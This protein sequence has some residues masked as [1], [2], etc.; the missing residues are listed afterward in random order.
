MR[1][2]HSLISYEEAREIINKNITQ[3]ERTEEVGLSEA[4]GRVLYEDIKS[5]VDV[6]PFNRAAMDGYAVRAE[7]T[8]GAGQFNPKILECIDVVHAG[9]VS[10][11]K[12]NMGQCIQIA[13]G[14]PLPVGADAVVMVED[15][16]KV[17]ISALKQPK[18]VEDTETTVSVLRDPRREAKEGR[19]TALH[20]VP[21]EVAKDTEKI[22]EEIQIFKPVYPKRNVSGKSE[23][24]KKGEIILKK[25]TILNSSRIGV[26]AAIG[27]NKVKIFEKPK[28]AVIPTGNEIAETGT[29]LKKGQVYDIN[30]YTL[31]S[32]VKQNGCIP[33]VHEIAIDTYNEIKNII[34]ESLK[35]DVVVLSGGSSVGERDVLVDVV[36]DL[37][38]VLFHGVQIKPGKPILCGKI[39]SKLVFGIPGYP[40]SCMTNAYLFLQPT[41]RKIARHPL[42]KENIIRT[43]ISK[44]VVST[45]G[46]HQFLTVKVE[47][48]LATP[49]FKESGAITSMANANGYIE[50]PINVDLI[51]KGEEV[52]VK[53]L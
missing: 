49:V 11:K 38:E 4:L 28:V 44:R 7:D 46:R 29:T 42:K 27:T 2:F 35:Y 13:T 31:S 48:N 39:E 15:T 37:G 33:I 6:P 26:L 18:V 21:P 43:K 14:A 51:E 1:P 23:D 10:D 53:L 32:I 36:R 12:V 20:S 22:E 3:I 16:D 40:T 45:L 17:F 8:F 41:L 50:I 25:G 9:E 34:I 24:I 5:R 47:G 30:S 19:T 52:E